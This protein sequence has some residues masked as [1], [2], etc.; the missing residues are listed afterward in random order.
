MN[1]TAKFAS[2]STMRIPQKLPGP[3]QINWKLQDIELA[4][5]YQ[6]SRERIRQIRTK[7]RIPKHPFSK[8]HREFAVKCEAILRAK[9]Q[10]QNRTYGEIEQI[11]GF[12]LHGFPI[13]NF[14]KSN[15]NLS[16]R[17]NQIPWED[18]NWNL[19]NLDIGGIWGAREYMVKNFR[20]QL[21]KGPPLFGP[22]LSPNHSLIKAEKQKAMK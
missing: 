2:R 8:K 3:D 19:A 1:L 11:L 7:Y 16:Y 17:K 4:E 21:K 20:K 6:C 15:V 12:T 5:L 13:R 22:N 18:V 14:L 9:D 10:L